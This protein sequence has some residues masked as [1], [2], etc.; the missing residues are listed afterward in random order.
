MLIVVLILGIAATFATPAVSRFIRHD[1]VNR[2]A[3]LIVSDLQN[4]FTVAGRQR[5]P[6]RLTAN[7]TNRTYTFSDRKTGTVISTRDFG[8]NSEYALTSLVLN[9][10]TL[11]VFPSGVSSAA[12]TATITNGDYSRTVTASTAGFVRITP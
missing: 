12:L 9:P 5:E 10:T 1:R 11:D 7:N 2:A 4:V 6:V 8:T 3:A